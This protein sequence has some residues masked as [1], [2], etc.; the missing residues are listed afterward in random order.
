MTD[1]DE[2]GNPIS[3][4]APAAADTPKASFEPQLPADNAGIAP[5][6]ADT[7]IHGGADVIREQDKIMLILAYLFPFVPFF[8]VK[9]SEYVMW[10]AR[11]GLV[12]WGLS[13]V[14]S[15]FCITIPLAF[16]CCGF[17]IK[18]LLEALK[19]NRWEAPC[20]YAIVQKIWKS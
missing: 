10:H 13:F 8:T 14:L 9:D 19:P 20:A 4:N 7:A 18:G 11:Q 12:L 5:V 2:N 16:V 1:L 3:G 15:L 17:A 6:S